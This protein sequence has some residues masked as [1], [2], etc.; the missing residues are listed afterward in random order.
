[1]LFNRIV[2]NSTPL[3]YVSLMDVFDNEKLLGTYD[4][5]FKFPGPSGAVDGFY[6]QS[7]QDLL[8]YRFYREYH[9][10]TANN[11]DGTVQPAFRQQCLL[12]GSYVAQC[13]LRCRALAKQTTLAGKPSVAKSAC[14]AVAK[15]KA[16]SISPEKA[17]QESTALTDRIS[18]YW[19]KLQVTH[20]SG[21][22]D[23]TYD[24]TLSVLESG[25]KKD[26]EALARV[27]MENNASGGAS[28]EGPQWLASNFVGCFGSVLEDIA[29]KHDL[30][31]FIAGVYSGDLE[32]D[33]RGEEFTEKMDELLIFNEL[34]DLYV[35]LAECT[36]GDQEFKIASELKQRIQLLFD[37]I[38]TVAPGEA[39]DYDV[40]PQCLKTIT[41][42][43][44][45]WEREK[46]FT[47]SDADDT[48]TSQAFM[49]TLV[50]KLRSSSLADLIF[51]VIKNAVGNVINDCCKLSAVVKHSEDYLG[52]LPPRV[53]PF[54][55]QAKAFNRVMSASDK[56]LDGKPCG[57][58]ELTSVLSDAHACLAGTPNILLRSAAERITM[59]LAEWDS[60]YAAFTVKTK[61]SLASMITVMDKY[62]NLVEATECWDFERFGL[63]CFTTTEDDTLCKDIQPL[64]SAI[65]HF[66]TNQKMAEALPLAL[67]PDAKQKQETD[68]IMQEHLAAQTYYDGLK[69]RL[70]CMMWCDLLARGKPVSSQQV[71]QLQKY[72][73]EKHNVSMAMM[74]KKVRSKVE[75]IMSGPPHVAGAAA[76]AAADAPMVDGGE[77]AAAAPQA[78]RRRRCESSDLPAPSRPDA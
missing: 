73:A 24:I 58:L 52:V 61:D 13:S 65:S 23:A 19:Q 38:K 51:I 4:K 78:K 53:Q 39:T 45:H 57:L 6:P 34:L 43:S 11:P 27:I 15:I 25:C 76:A 42:F 5:S 14:D 49:G 68:A 7:R 3:E 55:D 47:V 28:M 77:A 20:A 32:F 30:E 64:L 40:H 17:K 75:E 56:Q 69:P 35:L 10:H 41:S 22:L 72:L 37:V 12:F 59:L 36:M 26:L 31:A 44:K 63:G 2:K 62:S 8:C 16:S 50:A 54:I 74:P 70:A 1:M 60:A 29:E 21:D 46:S 66:R 67:G 48:S 9:V 18:P 33:G 71:Q